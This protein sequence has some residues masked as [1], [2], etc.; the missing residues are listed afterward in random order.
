M[1]LNRI[2]FPSLNPFFG[3]KVVVYTKIESRSKLVV[4]FGEEVVGRILAMTTPFVYPTVVKHQI[5]ICI[6]V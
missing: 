2:S 1:D 6:F 5:Y 4:L 3:I